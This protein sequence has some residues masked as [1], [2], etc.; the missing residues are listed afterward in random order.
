MHDQHVQLELPAES[1]SPQIAR[2]ALAP[3]AMPPELLD[4]AKLITSELVTNGVRHG[5]AEAGEFIRFSAKLHQAVLRIEVT[6]AAAVA[7]R[8]TMQPRG[9]L[10]SSGYG[11]IIVD[12]LAD[13]WGSDNDGA[14]RVW[15]ELDLAAG[16]KSAA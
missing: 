12:A 5:N 10:R 4:K 2:D 3:L 1:G 15:C 8:P 6:N 13:R 9:E 7:S 11:L 14:V 16:S